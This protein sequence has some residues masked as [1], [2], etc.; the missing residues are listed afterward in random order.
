MSMDSLSTASRSSAVFTKLYL[1]FI[2]LI[3]LKTLWRYEECNTTLYVLKIN[4]RLSKTLCY[5]PFKTFKQCK[6][7]PSDSVSSVFYQ[8][9]QFLNQISINEICLDPMRK[10]FY[11]VGGSYTGK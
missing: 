1:S 3:K 7:F 10:C 2:N 4:T 5:V 6:H 8:A 9:A 11:E